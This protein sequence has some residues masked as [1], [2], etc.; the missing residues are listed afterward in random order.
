MYD[1]TVCVFVSLIF[2]Y[3]F[4]SLVDDRAMAQYNIAHGPFV[5][6]LILLN[7]IILKFMIQD[8]GKFFINLK[9]FLANIVCG[10]FN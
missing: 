2:Y 5:H 10:N 8:T 3:R 1:E 6:E 9:F 7:I 4:L